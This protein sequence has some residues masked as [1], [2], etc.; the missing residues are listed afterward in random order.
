MGGN[1][2]ASWTCGCGSLNAGWRTTCGGCEERID[3]S[4]DNVDK[5]IEIVN[6]DLYGK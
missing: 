6:K 1:V 5:A 2:D 3:A 4:L